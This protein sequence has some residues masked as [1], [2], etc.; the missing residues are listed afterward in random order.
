M[1]ATACPLKWND[2]QHCDMRKKTAAASTTP[3]P[4]HHCEA[5]AIKGNRRK[6]TTEEAAKIAD[7]LFGSGVNELD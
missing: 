2:A 1:M 6:G 3:H 5:N 4:G 7:I